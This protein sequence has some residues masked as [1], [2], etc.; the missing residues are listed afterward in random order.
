MLGMLISENATP[1]DIASYPF[2]I[3]TEYMVLS[4][5]NMAK[6]C[7]RAAAAAVSLRSN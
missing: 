4:D 6:L 5:R 7:D 1:E 2:K 3:A